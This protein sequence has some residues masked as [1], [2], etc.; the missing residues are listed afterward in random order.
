MGAH[1]K[2]E[3]VKL[4]N[5]LIKKYGNGKEVNQ[6]MHELELE[7]PDY[8]K[9]INGKRIYVEIIGNDDWR[10]IVGKIICYAYYA[11]QEKEKYEIWIVTDFNVF[12]DIKKAKGKKR[13]QI[14]DGWKKWYNMLKEIVKDTR[15]DIEVIFMWKDENGL[16]GSHKKVK[17]K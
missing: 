11:R 1:R 5:L 2:K 7:G 17:L 14:T 12:N 3:L 10:Q 16:R 9:T 13:K 6:V 8:L 4:N 15:S